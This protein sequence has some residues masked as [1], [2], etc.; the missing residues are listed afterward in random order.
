MKSN[1]S[2]KGSKLSWLIKFITKQNIS[3]QKNYKL[4]RRSSEFCKFGVTCLNKTSLKVTSLQ[5]FFMTECFF[6]KIPDL[7][8]VDQLPHQFAS[9]LCLP[10]SSNLG[11]AEVGKHC[12][13]WRLS[14]IGASVHEYSEPAHNLFC[15]TQ[16]AVARQCGEE[17]IGIPKNI[18]SS[19]NTLFKGIL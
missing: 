5:F 17:I 16:W 14:Q 18:T 13:Q 19:R 6:E 12:E 15:L 3:T 8:C 10:K 7:F 9:Q 1:C 11:N 4:R 2:C